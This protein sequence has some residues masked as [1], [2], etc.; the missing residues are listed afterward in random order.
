MQ[1]K[2]LYDIFIASSGICTDNRH[3]R[4]DCI[5]WGL[6]GDNFDGGMFAEDA[7]EKG[8][9]LAVRESNHISNNNRLIHTSNSLLLLQQLANHH[10]KQF[11]IPV[12]AITGTNG[13]TTTKELVNSVLST[14]YN[15]H[16]TKGNFNNHIGVPL[17]LLEMSTDTEIAV[18][19][20]G[21]NSIGEIQLLCNIAEP[22]CGL[23]TNIGK[24]HLAGF[25]GIEG[26]KIAKAELYQ[27]L[28]Q[29]RGL[30]F[31]NIDEPELVELSAALEKKI[32]YGSNAVETFQNVSR[33]ELDTLEPFLQVSFDSKDYGRVVVNTKLLG[34]Y[35]FNNVMTAIVI[36]HYFK[37]PDLK[38]KEGL[39]NYIPG[40]NRS[41][42]IT[43]ST[44]TIILDAYNANPSSML[45]A[46]ENLSMIKSEMK[47]A[48]LG[49][50]FELG[51]VSALEHQEIV[52][53]CLSFHID[54]AVFVGSHF[55]KTILPK[56]YLSF[57][58]TE[59][60]K[61]WYLNQTFNN[62]CIL[63]KGSRG[64]KMESILN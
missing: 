57:E 13:K 24:A 26:V 36:G 63:I 8:A 53:L 54:L 38:I 1:L 4:K 62:A 55:H 44:N 5:F 16:Y 30:I 52:D 19:E 45:K 21:A 12:L 35:N 7:L 46:L 48:I 50:M 27:Y 33:V 9:I 43:K 47:V 51:E 61:K 37:V 64:M 25:G 22:T 31:V 14:Q 29:T 2:D 34:K 32:L 17:T 10:R 41:Q 40:N 6:K 49:D 15:T 58:N 18:I 11:E 42:L 60:V 23:I 39:E 56:H 20:M 28:D 59:Q 3:I